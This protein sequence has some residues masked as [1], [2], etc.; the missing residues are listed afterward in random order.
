M[1]TCDNVAGVLSL[2]SIAAD[3][4]WNNPTC[5]ISFKRLILWYNLQEMS[6]AYRKL[7]RIYDL[8][9]YDEFR[10]FTGGEGT[11]N[12]KKIQTLMKT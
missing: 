8:D 5:K 1:L 9:K 4:R 2:S 11:E 10:E 6:V 7:A 12:F 3:T